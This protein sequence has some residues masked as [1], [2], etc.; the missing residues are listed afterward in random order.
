MSFDIY[1]INIRVSI[2]V[3]GL[4]LFFYLVYGCFQLGVP[5]KSQNKIAAMNVE[6]AKLDETMPDDSNPEE[7][8]V[9]GKVVPLAFH[10]RHVYIIGLYIVLGPSK[11]K[12]MPW[13]FVFCLH[14]CPTFPD[15]CCCAG[16]PVIAAPATGAFAAGHR[17]GGL[18]MEVESK[19]PA[20]IGKARARQPQSVAAIGGSSE[21]LESPWQDAQPKP[22]DLENHQT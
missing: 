9:P 12:Y 22:E 5:K 1:T 8:S 3:R 17:A 10:S 21:S 7:P 2:R 18:T 13:P 19:K 14:T 20:G 16:A 11:F 15:L 4:H 6:L